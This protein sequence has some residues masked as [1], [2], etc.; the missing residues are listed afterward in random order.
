MAIFDTLA[1][2]MITSDAAVAEEADEEEV[3]EE[4]MTTESERFYSLT[5]RSPI[6]FETGAV[7][8]LSVFASEFAIQKKCTIFGGNANMVLVR[9]L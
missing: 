2:P 7:C 1:T 3:G 8:C 6:L 4:D 9:F 5:S